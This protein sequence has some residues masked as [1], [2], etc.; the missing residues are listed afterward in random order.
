MSHPTP[1]LSPGP[2]RTEPTTASLNPHYHRVE[3]L[4][5]VSGTM[6]AQSLTPILF[7]V[8]TLLLGHFVI[9]NLFTATL[10]EAFVNDD[11]DRRVARAKRLARLKAFGGF[12]K[13]TSRLGKSCKVKPSTH[14]G[15]SNGASNGDGDDDSSVCGV[16]LAALTGSE[17]QQAEGTLYMISRPRS[18]RGQVVQH[19][20]PLLG[21]IEGTTCGCCGANNSIRHACWKLLQSD[22][23]KLL[24][25]LLII[26]SC[27]CLVL[28]HP[29]L[30]PQ[31]TLAARLAL[32]NVVITALFT[33]EAA[34]NVIAYGLLSTPT[35]YLRQPWNLLDCFILLTSYLSFLG[36]SFSNAN[37]IRLLRVLR[38]LRLVHRV[39]GMSAIFSFFAQAYAD[40]ANVAGVVVFFIVIFAVIGMQLF[41]EIDFSQVQLSFESFPYAVLLLFVL[42]T[43]DEWEEFMWSAMDMPTSPGRP[44][45]RNDQSPNAIFF[46]VW[47]YIGQWLLINLFVATVVNNFVRIKSQEN[48]GVDPAEVPLL[49][50][51]QRQWQTTMLA[52]REHRRFVPEKA[53]PPP[54]GAV[55][56]WVYQLISTHAFNFGMS[57]VVALNLFVM[58]VKR[59][60]FTTLVTR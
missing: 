20:A 14:N 10:V 39:P 28:D 47:L 53:V 52:A 22:R 33:V 41:M 6:P 21:A 48:S 7:V 50:K 8:T 38:P 13:A 31:S 12:A 9:V 26:A 17:E 60:P 59:H 16:G 1:I 34:L 29:L 25:L 4:E 19:N 45:K 11:K 35:A 32:A 43:G 44:A 55:R 2:E 24:V 18:P 40:V 57:I 51:E 36:D 3:F 58:S 15:A 42:A 27:A 23:W 5:E 56:L 30:D 54:G 37:T 46:V 49:T